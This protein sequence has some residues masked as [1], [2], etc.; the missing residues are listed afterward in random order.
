[1]ASKRK[2]TTPCMVRASETMEQEDSKDSDAAESA[3]TS[4]KDSGDDLAAGKETSEN[5]C[6]VIEGK[7]SPANPSRKPLGGYECKYCPY[8]TQNLTDF[9]EHIDTQHPNVILN[10]LYVCAECNFTTKKYDLLS[11]HNTKLH[12]GENNFK[13]KLLKLDNQTVLEQSIEV[14][15]TSF[16]PEPTSMSGTNKTT[17]AGKLKAEAKKI[18]ID[19]HLDRL[20]HLITK[21]TEPITCING[22]ELF[23]D[24]LAHV[25]PSVQL[26]PNINLVPKVPVPLNITK[27]NSALDTNT[28]MINS[29]NKFPYPTQAELSW[30][31]AASKHPEE[32]IRIWFAIQRLKHGISWSPEE[33]EEARKKMFNGTIQAAPQTI[34][35]VPAH[36]T[37]AKMPQPLIQ[38]AVP[39]QILSQTGLVLTQVSNGSNV[40]P[41]TLAAAA[42]QGQKRS[43]QNQLAVPEAKRPHVVSA[44]VSSKQNAPAAPTSTTTI[45]SSTASNDRK[46]TKGQIAALKASFIISQFP[47]NAEIYRLIEITGLSRSEIKKWFSDHRYRC[48]RGIVNITNES[49]PKDQTVIAAARQGRNYSTYSDFT[50]QKFKG[51]T[52]EQFKILEESF[53][54]SSFPTPNEIERLRSEAKMSRREVETWFNERRKVRDN[55]EQAVLDSMGSNK[56]NKDQSTS[57][58]TLSQTERFKISQSPTSLSRCP[59]EFGTSSQEQVHLLK[60]MFA[61]TQWPSPQEYDELAA[62]TGLTRTE[63][64]RWFKENRS[65]LRTGKLKWLDQYQQQC[66]IDGYDKTKEPAPSDSMMKSTDALQQPKKERQK[67]GKHNIEDME[68]SECSDKDS[69]GN[70]DN[71]DDWVEV[72]IDDEDYEDEDASDCVDSWNQPAPESKADIDSENMSSD[73]SHT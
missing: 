54:K 13:L 8:S 34:T 29:F 49:I 10:P 4:E 27:Y 55:M 2:S 60:S 57:K 43:T 17:P 1:M 64:V 40:S 51:K 22:A 52:Q 16:A 18:S 56:K 15:N 35:V 41:V 12:P 38:T 69:Q 25:M 67:L 73:N 63:I 30:L 31:T 72:T 39:C 9:T 62:Q 5:D 23:Q 47:D 45:S 19:N 58:D 61:R 48:Q 7:S 26:P 68:K 36:V 11:E 44:E 37:A 70:N 6:E 66:V 20:S 42:N 71:K 65:F 21:T 24:I 28:T 50:F 32:Q 3:L 59:A 46:K 14:T 53:L 33:V